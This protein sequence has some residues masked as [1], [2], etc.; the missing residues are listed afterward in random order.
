VKKT[1]REMGTA[2]LVYGVHPVRELLAQKKRRVYDIFT[3]SEE[4]KTWAEIQPLLPKYP[5]SMHRL[6]RQALSDRLGTTDHQGIAALAE[7]FSYRKKFFDVARD[8]FLVMLDGIQ[9]V[10]NLGAIIRSAYCTGADGVILVQ[11]QGVALNAAALKASA[12][13]AERMSIYQATT[14]SVALMDLKHAGYNIYV[15]ALSDTPNAFTVEYKKPLCLVIGSEG[16]G[17]SYQSLKAGTV[18]TLPQKSPD[19]S[20]NASVAAG[21]IMSIVSNSFTK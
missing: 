19:V 20:Y 21:I 11:K 6:S 16:L 8:Q 2:E 13:L 14:P 9:D 10:R 15:A 3:L 18:V 7:P 12:G 17:V 1:P 4:P 5:Y